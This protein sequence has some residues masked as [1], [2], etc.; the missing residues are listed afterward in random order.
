MNNTCVSKSS[1]RKQ[2]LYEKFLKKIHSGNKENYKPF[3]CM[4]HHIFILNPFLEII[5]RNQVDKKCLKSMNWP[6]DL[7][8]EN[9]FQKSIDLC[10]HIIYLILVLVRAVTYIV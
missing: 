1:I 4:L 2:K 3:T 9:S 6:I 5:K 10:V 8:M 7:L